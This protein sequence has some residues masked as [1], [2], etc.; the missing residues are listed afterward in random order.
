[1]N[2]LQRLLKWLDMDVKQSEYTN[3]PD[4]CFNKE[5]RPSEPEYQNMEF[6]LAH[7]RQW[8]SI[9]N[10]EMELRSLSALWR[11]VLDRQNEIR[12]GQEPPKIETPLVKEPIK[13]MA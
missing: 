12:R 4:P 6:S 10:Q 3:K 2:L 11:L 13:E 8:R 1:M 9:N 5:Q 7:A